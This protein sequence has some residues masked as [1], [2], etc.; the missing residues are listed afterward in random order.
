MEQNM[1]MNI[2]QFDCTLQLIH[3]RYIWGQYNCPGASSFMTSLPVKHTTVEPF[4]VL[5]AIKSKYI[6]KKAYTWCSVMATIG[7]VHRASPGVHEEPLM[8][9][10]SRCHSELF[11]TLRGGNRAE[12]PRQHLAILK[13]QRT[14]T[15]THTLFPLLVKCVYLLFDSRGQLCGRWWMSF[16]CCS[17]NKHTNTPSSSVLSRYSSHRKPE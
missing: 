5:T 8:R 13:R 16:Q 2:D 1:T 6:G 12:E 7:P 3:K 11:A 9:S 14:R 15:H 10:L 17:V 4:C